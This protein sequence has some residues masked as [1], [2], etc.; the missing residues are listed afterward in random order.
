MRIT[1]RSS[2]RSSRTK[3]LNASDSRNPCSRTKQ[4]GICLSLRGRSLWVVVSYA[5]DILT[6]RYFPTNRYEFVW[7]SYSQLNSPFFSGYHSK[8]GRGLHS[9][10]AGRPQPGEHSPPLLG[11][12]VSCREMDSIQYWT[13]TNNCFFLQEASRLRVPAVVGPVLL[14]LGLQIGWLNQ[15]ETTVSGKA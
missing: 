2:K 3:S 15:E 11:W 12:E 10:P 6:W 4:K 5:K 9:P 14:G 13:R 8:N 1:K 7:Y